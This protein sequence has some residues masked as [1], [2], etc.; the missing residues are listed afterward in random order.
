MPEQQQWLVR[1]N[2][3]GSFSGGSGSGSKRGSGDRGCG[4]DNGSGT[5][6]PRSTDT[7]LI[8][9]PTYSGQLRLSIRKAHIFPLN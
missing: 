3:G 1:S 2:G 9:T 7:G 6:E 4:G 5:V 8:R